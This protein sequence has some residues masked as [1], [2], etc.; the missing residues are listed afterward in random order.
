MKKMAGVAVG[1]A[2][3]FVGAIF[4]AYVF[5]DT[6]LFSLPITLLGVLFIG[7][8]FFMYDAFKKGAMFSTPTL[9]TET[10]RLHRF[11]DAIRIVSDGKMHWVIIPVG[12]FQYLKAFIA[13][14]NF[15]P[16]RGHI[17]LMPARLLEIVGS[18]FH[19]GRVQL[20]ELEQNAIRHLYRIQGFRRVFDSFERFPTK[21]YLGVGSETLHPDSVDLKRADIASMAQALST[22]EKELRRVNRDLDVKLAQDLRKL[23]RARS[24][25]EVTKTTAAFEAEKKG[26]EEAG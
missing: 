9:F 10:H 8:G 11:Q 25:I 4:D 24:K 15:G 17:V 19:I 20:I 23:E 18:R 1:I 6:D 26:E 21:L 12:G 3:P 13:P 5:H 14:K 2:A 7:L 22:G 16:G